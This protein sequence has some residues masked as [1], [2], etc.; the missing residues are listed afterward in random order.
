MELKHTWFQY[1]L[2]K[3]V[4]VNNHNIHFDK[5]T[6]THDIMEI[7]TITNQLFQNYCFKYFL[8]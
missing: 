4:T 6:H 8:E 2:N 5:W 7:K 1:L 3:Y